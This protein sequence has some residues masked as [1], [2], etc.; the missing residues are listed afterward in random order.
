LPSFGEAGQLLEVGPFRQQCLCVVFA[1][2]HSQEL[3]GHCKEYATQK[4]AAAAAAATA[5]DAETAAAATADA[6]ISS[7][8]GVKHTAA[9]QTVL[10]LAKESAQDDGQ[11]GN[12]AAGLA[13]AA[14]TA[15][16][17]AATR[18]DTCRRAQQAITLIVRRNRRLWRLCSASCGHLQSKMSQTLNRDSAGQ[19]WLGLFHAHDL[20]LYVVFLLCSCTPARPFKAQAHARA[21]PCIRVPS[22]S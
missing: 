20:L 22:L 5:M 16:A 1:V 6:G 18:C 4:A 15:A 12:D 9:A 3:D 10:E 2:A 19:L 13:A 7:S 21:V 8:T 11:P 14:A 17:E